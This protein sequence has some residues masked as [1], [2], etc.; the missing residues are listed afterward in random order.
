MVTGFVWMETLESREQI[1]RCKHRCSGEKMVVGCEQLG[2]YSEAE[3]N[4]G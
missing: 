2:F 1:V 4:F 3:G